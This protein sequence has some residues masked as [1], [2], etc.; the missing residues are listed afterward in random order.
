VLFDINRASGLVPFIQQADAT[1]LSRLTDASPRKYRRTL[2]TNRIRSRSMWRNGQ[3]RRART[4]IETRP[5]N[6]AWPRD[7]F[8]LSHSPFPFL[9][10]I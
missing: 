6:A 4:T 9:C 1:L 2:I 8:S 10:P 5:L 3:S 7:V